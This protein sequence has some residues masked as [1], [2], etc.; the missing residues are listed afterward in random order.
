MK[1]LITEIL[2]TIYFSVVYSI[3]IKQMLQYIK[4]SKSNT[5]L[6]KF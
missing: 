4:K 6:Q 5:K 3:V 1:K 2:K